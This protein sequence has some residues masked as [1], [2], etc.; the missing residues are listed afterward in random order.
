MH[1]NGKI[2]MFSTAPVR[3]KDDLS[4]A[5]TPGVARVCTA[6]QNDPALSHKYTIRKNTVAIVSNGPAVLGLGDIGPEGAMPVMEG[7]ALLFKE[8]SQMCLCRQRGVSDV[9]A[10]SSIEGLRLLHGTLLR[11]S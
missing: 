2:Q 1:E 8:E 5:Y 9:S 7:K 11:P 6:I 3:D 10:L 4:M